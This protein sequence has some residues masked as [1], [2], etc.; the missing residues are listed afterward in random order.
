M[1]PARALLLFVL[2]AAGTV[3][4]APPG[5]V[6]RLRFANP[7]T[8]SWDPVS[9]ATRYNLYRGYRRHLSSSF[10]GTV[11][12]PEL[13]LTSAFDDVSPPPGE[14][15]FYLVTA[16]GD[17][18]SSL[19]FDGDGAAR[20]NRFAWPGFAVAGQW[21]Q[22]IAWPG[23]AVHL[24]VLR[25][26]KVLSWEGVPAP[27]VTWLW[28][29]ATGGFTTQPLSTNIFCA[30]HTQ[31]AD[32]RILV[33]GGN[34]EIGGLGPVTSW[35]YT[36]GASSPWVRGPDMRNGRYYPSNV[37]LGDGRI[38]VFAGQ[39][40]DG[41]INEQ[42]ESFVQG[43][44][45]TSWFDL[46]PGGS[47]PLQN[48]PMM[49]LLPG[50]HLFHAGPEVY[51]KTFDPVAQTWTPV[52]LS[53]Y[54]T[55]TSG[56][57]VMLPPFHRKFLVAGGR[58]ASQ[59]SAIAT[60]SAEVIDLAQPTPAWRTLTPMQFE[61][62]YLNSVILP[63][64]KVLV[65]GGGV[66]DDI[67]VH[68]SELFDPA[69]ESWSMMASQRSFRLYH[70]TAVLLPDATVLSAGSNFNNTAEIYR[71]G[72]LFRGARPTISSAPA[73][74]RYGHGFS[75]GTAAPSTIQSVVLLRPGAATHAFNQDQR[76]VPLT[77]TASGNSLQ[78]Q[79][80]TS[81]HRAPPGHYM[82]FILN[83]LGVPSVASWV[84]LRN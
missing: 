50:G 45:G 82:L 51:T 19:G 56:T 46:L 78:V 35:F 60:A 3:E 16:M 2:A 30:G 8:L 48:Y 68:P 10:Y 38:L 5:E 32:G 57:A 65:V 28:D 40:Q 21:Q 70:S 1:H 39:R 7:E 18:E 13:P 31:L 66:N 81:V 53:D 34:T 36:P 20:A 54:G 25:T 83:N 29:P 61:R 9:G 23:V 75:V 71:P 79:P 84:E 22:P 74:L 4:A 14:M 62:L 27:S 43:P 80:P 77:F 58:T 44:G 72:Y 42:V 37:T 12:E 73:T 15:F 26:G 52:D 41:L 76:Y 49:F 64:G 47:W 24:I 63:D 6:Q 33:T 17:G 11:L 69:T 67:P 55:R 59:H